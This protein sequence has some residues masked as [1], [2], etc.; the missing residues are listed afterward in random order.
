MSDK[1]RGSPRILL[2]EDNPDMREYIVRLLASRWTIDAVAD[3]QAALDAVREDPP[4]LVLSDVMMPRL[5][6]V[7]LLR[8]LRKDPKTSTIPLIL[9]SARAGEE[10]VISGLDTG[11]DD[12]LVKPFSA[13][14]LLS[15]VRTHLELARARRAW[16]REIER[17]NNELEAFSY[18]VS[19]DL[20]APLRTIDGFSQALL[21]TSGSRVDHQGRHYLERIRAATTRMS[22][23]IEGLLGLSRISRTPLR[24]EPVD[25]SELA[26]EVA[27]ELQRRDP[28]R[29]VTFDVASGLNATGDRQLIR[30]VLDNLIGN[31]WK[32]TSKRPEARIWVGSETTP[33]GVAFFVRDNGAGFDMAYAQRLFAP[34]QRL[35]QESDFEGTGIGLATVQRIISG[36]GGRLTATGEV[37]GGAKF[38]FTLEGDR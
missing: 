33:G 10:A 26:V 15:R 18:S 30:V 11:A 36:H 21:R 34:F 38:V 27:E 2:A 32:F 31:A 37:E 7:G 25:L 17:V 29:V 14:E 24:R 5:N 8:A 23:L 6:G 16:S 1:E 19:H 35:H 4:D 28:A 3:G 12:Y 9:L 13:P 22:A 20:R